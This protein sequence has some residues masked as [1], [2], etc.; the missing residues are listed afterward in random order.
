MLD[1]DKLV[2]EE[3]YY[4]LVAFCDHDE[5]WWK[6]KTKDQFNLSENKCPKC[7]SKS[8]RQI[9]FQVMS[10][11]TFQPLLHGKKKAKKRR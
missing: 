9:G 2:D 8:S 4:L 3:G 6:F 11:R 1:Y 7:G 10:Q 5:E